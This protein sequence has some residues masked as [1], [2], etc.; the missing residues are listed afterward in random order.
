[1]FSLVERLMQALSA[2]DLTQKGCR[3][4]IAMNSVPIGVEKSEAIG[5]PKS[6]SVGA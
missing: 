3:G 6:H 5:S 4:E 2:I 1:M